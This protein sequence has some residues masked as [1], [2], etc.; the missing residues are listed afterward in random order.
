M[1]RSNSALGLMID[2][3]DD[4]VQ[5]L[6]IAMVV[7][8]LD[9]QGKISYWTC[10]TPNLMSVEILGMMTWGADVALHNEEET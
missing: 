1:S 2:C 6:E 8:G 9:D 3:P 5:P 7:K 4:M 10:S